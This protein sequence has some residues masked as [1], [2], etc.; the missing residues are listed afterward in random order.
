MKVQ[1][2]YYFFMKGFVKINQLKMLKKKRVKFKKKFSRREKKILK[3]LKEER[4]KVKK[5]FSSRKKKKK[6]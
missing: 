4:V 3:K 2:D 6:Y 1:K 5:K